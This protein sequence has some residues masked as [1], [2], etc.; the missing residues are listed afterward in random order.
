MSCQFGAMTRVAY[1][2]CVGGLAGDML[3]AA[4]LDAG[5][6][7]E[8]LDDLPGHLGIGPVNVSVTRVERQGVSA[9]HVEFEPAGDHGHRDW[10]SIRTLLE[11]STFSDPVRTRALGAF[12]RL[13]EAE[14]QVHGVSPDDVHFHELGAVDT[15]MDICGCIALLDA[16]GIDEV[17][18]S[19]LPVA[20]GHVSAAHGTLPLPAPA[21]LAL[22]RGAPLYGVPTGGEL[23][24]PTGAA[25]AAELVS[26]WGELPPLTF[27]QV[28][29]GA[30]ARELDDRANVVRL[31]IGETTAAPSTQAVTVLETNL[32]DLSP[33]LVPDAVAACFTAGALDV[34][35]VPALMKKGRPGIVFSALTKREDEAAVA[36]A[37]LVHTSALGVR[38][39]HLTRYE[40]DREER[41]IEI[42]G[43]AIRVKFGRLDGRIVNVAPEHDDC[44][45]VAAKTGGSV[46]SV[47]A[48]ALAAAGK[49]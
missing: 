42:D 37:I 31:L 24:T 26:T 35:T 23:V 17:V 28:G 44:A 8:I 7:P 47:W 3:V 6:A 45:A 20:R 27:E 16:L 40:L 13:A 30:G 21:T 15:L 12:R 32:D 33:E 22:L 18:C 34:W 10:R 9:V 25:L 39:A 14:A 38:I 36:R 43:A 5:A 49:L 48:A 4:S 29:V 41:T 46:Q 11:E 19:P 1:L 2:D